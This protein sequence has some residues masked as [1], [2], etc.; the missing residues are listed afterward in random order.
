MTRTDVEFQSEG[1]TLRGW[2][3]LPDGAPDGTPLVVMAHGFVGHRE[4]VA[5]TAEVFV[6]RGLACLVYDYPCFGASD[7]EPRQEV[8]PARQV[9]SYRDAIT[10]AGNQPGIDA[11]RIGIWG[12]S[13]GGA[14]VLAVA[15][16][17]GHRIRAVVSQVPAVAGL[18][19]FQRLV[20]AHQWPD[21]LAMIEADR[22]ARFTGAAPTTIPVVSADP[23]VPGALPGQDTYEWLMKVSKDV[24]G[25]RNEVTV[26]SLDLCFE[27]T[28]EAFLER[29]APVPI[30]MTLAD[31]DNM[32][33]TELQLAAYQRLREP[34]ELQLLH[35]NH[36]VA[37]ES[38]FEEAAAEQGDFLVRHLAG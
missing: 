23:E 11:G 30:L 7:G 18:Q 22:Q 17:D 13:M 31:E 36:Y 28:P 29:V 1:T 2:L 12:T 9:R 14:H 4:W 8:D 20:P 5:P 15:G 6:E 38:G 34:K 21:V 37:Y 25:Y 33:V 24:P 19:T 10:F 26:R 27:Y 35:G 32:C 3:Y 16:V